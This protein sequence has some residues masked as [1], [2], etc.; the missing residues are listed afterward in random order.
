MLYWLIIF[1]WWFNVY[2]H[3]CFLLGSYIYPNCIIF[4]NSAEPLKR[5]AEWS[6][7]TTVS[8]EH[9]V[10]KVLQEPMPSTRSLGAIPKKNRT[11][12]SDLRK[13]P[14]SESDKCSMCRSRPGYQSEEK[15]RN[16]SLK[17]NKVTQT[18]RQSATPS[19]VDGMECVVASPKETVS[20]TNKG[21]NV[22]DCFCS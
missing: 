18:L 21:G 22:T 6:S 12:Q 19:P 2:F 1:Y 10:S 13:P 14:K 15:R 17:E 9:D 20:R 4:E 3:R 11:N 7:T 5:E 16:R 8:L